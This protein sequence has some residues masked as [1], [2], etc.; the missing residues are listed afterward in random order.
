MLISGA[1]EVRLHKAAERVRDPRVQVLR[2]TIGEMPSVKLTPIQNQRIAK[3][4]GEIQV[5]RETTVPDNPGRVSA[6][7]RRQLVLL[8]EPL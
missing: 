8:S 7:S 5:L 2:A 4:E 6:N 1:S 3:L